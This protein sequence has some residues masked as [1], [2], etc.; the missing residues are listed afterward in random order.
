RHPAVRWLWVFALVHF[1][2]WTLV[3]ALVYP[4]LPL[5]ATEM[6]YWGRA[7]Q[8]GYFKHP[9]LPA[10][11]ADV[12]AQL[13]GA[14]GLYTVS[15]LAVVV[16]LYCAW[17]VA[18]DLFEPE[19]AVVAAMCL[20]ACCNYNQFSTDF[21]NNVGQMP[22]WALAT[23]G[24]WLAVRTGRA[25]DWVL[26]GAGLGLALLAKYSAVLLAISILA[27]LVW[28]PTARRHW[29]TPGP[30]IAAATCLLVFAPHLVWMARHDFVT[31]HYVSARAATGGP[32][33]WTEHLGQPLVFALAQ[34]MVVAPALIPLVPYLTWRGRWHRPTPAERPARRFVGC[35]VCGPC[36]LLLGLSLLFGIQ[37]R[38]MW[39][40]VLWTFSGVL[41]LMLFE[42]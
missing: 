28:E 13:G 34:A 19:L 42:H 9:P 30:A 26:L 22:F 16:S 31:L 25:R 6:A 2:V 29:R 41:F 33:T 32:P 21:N 23:L 18:R 20:E 27:Y 38:W 40:E 35:I 15:Q 1:G 5:D 11:L 17:R 3:P 14:W 8:W 7:W 10:W 24:A 36:A 39:G 4:N 37:L 12:A